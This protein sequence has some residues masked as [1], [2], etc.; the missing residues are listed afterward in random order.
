MPDNWLKGCQSLKSVVFPASIRTIGTSAFEDCTSLS[1]VNLNKDIHV[2]AGAFKGTSLSGTI[3][4][5][6]FEG[7]AFSGTTISMIYEHS[8]RLSDFY[9]FDNCLLSIPTSCTICLKTS[10]Y[11]ALKSRINELS[12]GISID[13]ADMSAYFYGKIAALIKS[14]SDIE[15]AIQSMSNTFD[16]SQI[17]EIRQALLQVQEY[18]MMIQQEMDVRFYE[19]GAKIDNCAY[20]FYAAINFKRDLAELKYSME[21]KC[22]SLSYRISACN[23]ALKDLENKANATSPHSAPGRTRASSGSS[24]YSIDEIVSLFNNHVTSFDE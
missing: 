14:L 22:S 16:Y 18:Y 1:S 2:K 4:V 5:E 3:N 7:D 23:N 8:S 6:A 21:G 9:E 11:S 15:Q 24:S 10:I 20:Y 13:L 12:S 19:V 17:D